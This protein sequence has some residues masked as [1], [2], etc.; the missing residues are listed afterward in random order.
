MNENIFDKLDFGP[1]RTLL[2]DDDITDISFDNGGQ[3]WIR[4]LSQGSM[5]VEVQ[6][7]TTEFIE[8]LAFQLEHNADI[9]AQKEIDKARNYADGYKQAISDL[10]KVVKDFV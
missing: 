5:R 8:K 4:S 6:G 7:L 3:V 1:L 10:L 2:D 9:K